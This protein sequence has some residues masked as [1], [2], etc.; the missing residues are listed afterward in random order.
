MSQTGSVEVIARGVCVSRGQL[1]LCRSVGAAHT[2]LPGGHIEFCERAQDSLRREIREELGAVAVVGALLGI[3]QHTFIQRGA[4]HSELN[5]VFR[6]DIAELAS[7][8]AP[9]AQEEGIEF[10]WHPLADLG[11]SG[12]EP[13]PLRARLG[14]WLA[15]SDPAPERLVTSGGEWIRV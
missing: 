7:D 11:C 8:R 13:E 3:A 15:V 1:L 6:M 10:L 2:Y 5:L 14:A 9:I 4:P 12:L